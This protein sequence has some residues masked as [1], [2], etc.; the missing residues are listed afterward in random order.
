MKYNYNCGL[1][2]GLG[3]GLSILIAG[4]AGLRAQQPTPAPAL[5]R[6]PVGAIVHVGREAADPGD[7][8]LAARGYFVRGGVN[9]MA[10]SDFYPDGHQGGVS[11][12]QQGVR[13]A[14]NGDIRLDVTPGQWSPV[15]RQLERVVDSAAAEIRTRLA[16]PDPEKNRTGFNPIEYPDL[17]LGYV[18]RVRAEGDAVH[19]VV[20]F[21]KPVPAEW[22]ARIGFNLE[23]YP[24][25]LFGRSWYLGTS[26]GVFP[27][28]A[29]GPVARE[30]GGRE[31]P[32]ALATGRRLVLAPESPAQRL[33][34]ESLTG[35]LA[36]YDG[37]VQYNNG[38]FVVRSLARAGASRGAVEWIV[39]PN[40]IPGWRYQPVVQVSQVGY[41]P[42]E[43]KVAVL[44]LDPRDSAV[45]LV[46]LE[47]VGEDGTQETVLA[48]APV[49]WRAERGQFL[50]YNYAH[51]DFSSVTRP[52][53]YRIEYRGH[54][55]E[56]FRIA[57]DIFRRD[58][59]QPT[60]DYFL[61]VQ[62]CHMRV[63]D[64][65]R[66]WHGVDHLDDARMA[67]VAYNHFDGYL[68]GPSTLT[69]FRP[70]ETV[71]GLNAG[72]W[73]DAGD[74]DLRLESQADEVYILASMYELFH[75][76]YD[77]TSIDEQSRQVFI[78][79]PDGKPDL[80]Q[81]VEHG[82]LTV[83][84]SY[85]ALGRFYRGIIVPTLPQYT[86][87]GDVS[88][89]T[90]NL[91]FDS[92]LAR[93]AR[94]GTTSGKPDDRWVFTEQNPEHEYKGI[95]ALAIAARVLA[96][97]EPGLAA[98]ALNAAQ[99]LW[100]QPRD[101]S[102]GFDEKVVAASE[103]LLST[104]GEP[105]RAFLLEHRPQLVARIGRVGWALGRT[106]PLV[107]DSSF[108]H[109]IRAAVA[110][111]FAGVVEA[112]KQS[113]YGVPYQPHIWGAGWD[114]QRFGVQQ[115]FLHRAFPDIVSAEYM[116][117]ALNFVL[118]VHPGS[119]T[120]SFASGV[121]ARSMTTA[122][123]YNRGDWSYIPGGVVSGTALIRPDFPELKDFPFLWQQAEYVMGGGATHF[124]FLVLAADQ[125]LGEEPGQKAAPGGR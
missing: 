2:L 23:L 62:M 122:Y 76:D 24:A 114:I 57:A 125:V 87:I 116:L 10:F 51:F 82:L 4:A 25:E 59:W 1:G 80:L 111:D 30:P 34:I 95:A 19:I 120:A 31:E 105:Y 117:N 46:R 88:N 67:P 79:R 91:F 41:H 90:D 49:P 40:A 85:R 84:G 113:P 33:T 35:D 14:S 56:P 16:Y 86:L 65:Y 29:N 72:G 103:L 89:S 58:V 5:D 64:H 13:V 69:R 104:R 83:L 20:D 55:T 102:R 63:E 27:R 110:R 52:G 22:A 42:A 112:Q 66:V 107:G 98:E 12:I 11:I 21:E 92:T 109:A 101:T 81:Q 77:A 26:S 60:I 39:R 53:V 97:T 118:G 71:P 99:E 17:D 48:R 108:T 32:R 100:R 93:G 75:L 123:G 36:L 61:P 119:N 37:R 8:R 9:V 54:G 38:W 7:F 94:T 28:Q 18:V 15:P 96:A 44:E 115:Y 45:G 106:L 43:K 124:M 47:R 68:Q 3:L 70:G 50:R 6:R 74:D 78:H 73:H 121:G